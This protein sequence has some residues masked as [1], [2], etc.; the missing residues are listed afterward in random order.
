VSAIH[1]GW[2]V[3]E[4]LREAYGVEHVFDKPIDLPRFTRTIASLLEGK[5]VAHDEAT[6]SAAAEA[7]LTQGMFAFETGDL[8]LAIGHL[9]AGVA[10][11]PLAFEL[12]YHLGLLHGRRDDLFSAIEAL[13]TAVSLSPRHFAALKNLAVVYQ[14]AGFRHKALEVWQRA[15]TNAPDDETRANIK[16][17]MVTLL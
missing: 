8:E 3:A 1:R 7:E 9:M 12:Q 15:L 16:E 14:R 11:D 6:L 10:I 4:D 17:H 2:R 5:P 13:E